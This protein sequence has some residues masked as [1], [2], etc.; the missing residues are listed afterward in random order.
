[1]AALNAGDFKVAYAA[2]AMPIRYAVE[3][4]QWAEAAAIVPAPGA[5]PYVS[6]IAVWA[7]GLALAWG[8]HQSAVGPEADQLQQLESRLRDAHDEYW[9]AQ[10]KILRQ[11]LMAWTEHA[12]GKE[13][14]AFALMSQT[15]DEEDAIE[16][17]PVT[18]GPVIPARE[19]LG[20]LL[21]LQQ[22]SP[23][24]ARQFTIAL[25]NAPGRRGSIEGLA[26]ASIAISQK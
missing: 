13:Q 14:E 9:A 17:L 1:M 3:R 25:A 7:R 11:E 19:Q 23:E 2:T 24:A 5:P 4:H 12:R 18:P 22:R 8:Q 6:A 21:L 16:K 26:S 15:A 20:Y 10:V